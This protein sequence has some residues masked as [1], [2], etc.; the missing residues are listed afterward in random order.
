MLKQLSIAE[1][2][3]SLPAVVHDVEEGQP[4]EITRRG[5]PVAVLLSVHEYRRLNGVV[6]DF[7]AAVQ[8]FRR[9][10]DLE[11]LQAEAAFVDL[12]DRSAGR[13]FKW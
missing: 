8:S 9:E 10:H 4:V 12:H 13:N 2:K 1:A 3:N 6:P 7:W 11:A 5:E